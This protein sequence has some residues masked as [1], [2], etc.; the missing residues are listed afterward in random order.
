MAFIKAMRNNLSNVSDDMLEALFLKMDTDGTGLITWVRR[1]ALLPRSP[2]GG[3]EGTGLGGS[4]KHMEGCRWG[5]HNIR[6][7]PVD[8]GVHA[9][10]REPSESSRG[11]S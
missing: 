4:V 1:A 7:P 3:W 2:E 8:S 11:P 5:S 10:W 9:G 6:K